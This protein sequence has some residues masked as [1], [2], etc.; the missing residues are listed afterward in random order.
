MILRLIG[1]DILYVDETVH[2]FLFVLS[3]GWL[4]SSADEGHDKLWYS[5]ASRM[6]ALNRG[7]L[8]WTSFYSE[9][10]GNP[11][12]WNVLVPGGKEINWDAV[13]KS[14]RKQHKA[15]WIFC[16]NVGEMWC[17]DFLLTILSDLKLLGIAHSR[18]WQSRRSS[19]EW[20]GSI[21]SIVCRISNENAGGINF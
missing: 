19:W 10:K 7:C 6:W 5:S 20:C 16:S 12:N 13:S 11:G 1:L 15:N 9:T 4:G 17:L 8:N 18:G 3:G 2:K 21:Q 14:D